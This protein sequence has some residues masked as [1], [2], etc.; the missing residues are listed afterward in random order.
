MK[1]LILAAAVAAVAA[2]ALPVSAAAATCPNGWYAR[3][4]GVINPLTNREITY[5]YPILP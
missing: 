4:S 1:R 3:G 5:C 2:S